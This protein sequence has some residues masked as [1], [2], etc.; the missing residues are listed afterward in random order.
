MF[1]PIDFQPHAAEIASYGFGKLLFSRLF[2]VITSTTYGEG[3]GGIY[4]ATVA[5]LGAGA[6]PENNESCS[7]DAGISSRVST[8][9]R[10]DN[11]I[12]PS[13][14]AIV[15]LAASSGVTS[16]VTTGTFC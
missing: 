13:V 9:L 3:G 10:S 16:S 4:F 6:P 15:S 1:S 5:R 2:P 12:F 11:W 7:T 8:V 14:L